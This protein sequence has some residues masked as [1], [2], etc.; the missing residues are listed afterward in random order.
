LTEKILRSSFAPGA[1]IMRIAQETIRRY[2][3]VRLSWTANCGIPS[4]E[5]GKDVKDN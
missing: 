1:V 3:V 2:S 4:T 5:K